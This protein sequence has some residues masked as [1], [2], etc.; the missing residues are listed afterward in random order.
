VNW[1]TRNNE[2]ADV[3]ANSVIS[4]TLALN[5]ATLHTATF[6]VTGDFGPSSNA[7]VQLGNLTEQVTVT[8]GINTII[9]QGTP[10][11]DY[12]TLYTL[13][14]T[15]IGPTPF[16]V[17]SICLVEGNT[18]PVTTCF[19]VNPTFD[20][21]WEGWTISEPS[22]TARDGVAWVPID[23]DIRQTISLPGGATYRV[24]I[25]ARVWIDD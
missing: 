1:N 7:V 19:L 4:Q 23:Q 16:Y 3:W 14:L 20:L 17:S 22:M 9:L 12:G 15:N 18:T 8:P 2:G 25:D 6:E 5:S 13:S 21:G 10:T 11:P 24:S